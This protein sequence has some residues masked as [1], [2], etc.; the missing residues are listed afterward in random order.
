MSKDK[1]K[2]KKV[3]DI[4]ETTYSRSEI[5]GAAS[6]FKVKPEMIA[7]ALRLTDKEELT[8]SEVEELLRKF[9]AK[10]V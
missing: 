7:G 10:K 8:R 6:S 4:P 5:L 9:K 1:P 2:V 3:I